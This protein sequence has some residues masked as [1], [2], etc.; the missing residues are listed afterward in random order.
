MKVGKKGNGFSTV[1]DSSDGYENMNIHNMSCI[2]REESEQKVDRK[3]QSRRKGTSQRLIPGP[4]AY[5]SEAVA[6]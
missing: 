1:S 5:E 3:I 4:S 6:A 2:C